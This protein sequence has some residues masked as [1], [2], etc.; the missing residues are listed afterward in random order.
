MGK[1]EENLNKP[2]KRSKYQY[3]FS[4]GFTANA[5][6][7]KPKTVRGGI[8]YSTIDTETRLFHGAC[9]LPTWD[10]TDHLHF[11]C[12][13]CKSVADVLQV[14]FTSHYSKTP[15]YALFFYLGCP[16][17]GATGQRKIYFDLDEAR[18]KFQMAWHKNVLYLYGDQREPTEKINFKPEK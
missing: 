6:I 17:C 7:I 16:E 9:F 5:F 1:I 18:C 2:V 12:E 10:S 4:N 13:H 3:E 15:R 14:R 11:I 8:I